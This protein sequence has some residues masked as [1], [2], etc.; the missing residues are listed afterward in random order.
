[1]KGNPGIKIVLVL[2]IMFCVF[3]PDVS[4]AQQI[5]KVRIIVKKS[6]IRAEPNMQ[7][8]VID[9][10]PLGAVF[11]VIEKGDIWYKIKLNAE[12]YGSTEGYLNKMFVEE[13][14]DEEG[15][16]T[17]EEEEKLVDSKEK[18]EKTEE[19]GVGAEKEPLMPEFPVSGQEAE[20]EEIRAIVREYTKAMQDNRLVLFYEQNCVS[21]LYPQVREDADWITR[22]YDRVNSCVSD[23][24][25]MFVNVSGADVSLSLIITGLPRVGGS[26]KLLFEG[27]YNWS[28]IKQDSGWKIT[29]VTSQPYK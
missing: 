11:E 1:M 13:L 2:F 7:S 15:P 24:S 10:P 25:I 29:G 16:V 18:E 21:E 27:T 26:R 19:A 5:E 9:S 6:S 14:Q 12:Q 23:I 4:Q 20:E 8:K 3:S 28:M 22:T 17:G